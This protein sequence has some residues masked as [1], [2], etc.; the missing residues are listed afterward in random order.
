M[1]ACAPAAADDN[2]HS[3][4][5]GGVVDAR[6][7]Q[8]QEQA[9]E[10][11]Q[12]RDFQRAYFIYRNEL[13]P[14]GDKYA[15]YTLGFMYLTGTGV[16]ED[17]V[18]ASAWYRLAAERKWPQLVEV[19]DELLAQ[20]DDVELAQS[21][22]EYRALRRELSDIVLY[23]RLAQRDYEAIAEGMTGSRIGGPNSAI[24]IVRPGDGKSMSADVWHQQLRRS[25]QK[26]LDRVTTILDVP[27]LDASL[28]ED[29]LDGLEQQVMEYVENI[30]D[31]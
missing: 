30:D 23:L 20:F 25:L 6:T 27:R 4:R 16:P 26:N 1:V 29:E 17:R 9:D 8:V 19:R 7:L 14:I 18:M 15:Q 21:D 28:T 12:R 2:E 13:A 10:L 31:R 22:R 5:D 24:T 11:F 3:A